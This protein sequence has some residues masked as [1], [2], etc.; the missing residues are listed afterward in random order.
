M[1]P[2]KLIVLL[3]LAVVLALFI[4]FNLNNKCEISFVFGQVQAVPV[5]LTILISFV[6]GLVAA[7]PFAFKRTSAKGKKQT[8][9]AANSSAQGGQAIAAEPS[10]PDSETDPVSDLKDDGKKKKHAGS[11]NAR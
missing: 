8:A 3:A 5:Y 1:I 11:K 2:W 7:L 6:A 4:G 9:I 10:A